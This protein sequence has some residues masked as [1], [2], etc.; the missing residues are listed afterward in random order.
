VALVGAVFG[1]P[2]SADAVDPHDGVRH[3]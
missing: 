2:E 3:V 1:E